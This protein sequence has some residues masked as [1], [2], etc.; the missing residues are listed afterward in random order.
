MAVLKNKNG[1]ELYIDC[2]CGC[3][4]GVRFKIDQYDDFDY[5]CFM[6]YTNGNFYREQG[7]TL[8][9][10]LSKKLEKIWAIIRNKDFYYAEVVMTKDEFNEFREYINSIE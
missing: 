4:E 10:I 3:N 2:C 6:T 5:Y 9:G 7:D 8:W 1:K